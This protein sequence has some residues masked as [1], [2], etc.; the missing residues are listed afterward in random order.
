MGISVVLRKREDADG[1]CVYAF[2]PPETEV[3]RVALDKAT[4]DVEILELSDD[5]RPPGEKFFLAQ[6]IP[7]LHAMH[8]DD[9]WPD[10]DR[11]EA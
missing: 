8:A 6:V 7:R 2:G 3:G 1:R 10:A 5:V 9:D 4:G 11:W